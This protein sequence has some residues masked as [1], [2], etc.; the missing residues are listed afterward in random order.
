MLT[1]MPLEPAR[2]ETA[3]LVLRPISRALAAAI[4]AG[5]LSSVHPGEGWPHTDTAGGLRRTLEYGG[6]YG[7]LVTLDGVAIG[8]CGT[9]GDVNDAG[10]VEIGYGLAKPDHGQGHGNEV[11][12]AL[13]RG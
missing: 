4:V 7:W 10:E 1:P 9:H 8:D 13:S 5:D 6:P 3:R 11:V 2:I 12:A